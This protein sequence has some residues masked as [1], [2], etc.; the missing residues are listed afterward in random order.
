MGMRP[1]RPIRE[2]HQDSE[3]NHI[4]LSN[5]DTSNHE[6][7]AYSERST[8]VNEDAAM[9]DAFSFDSEKMIMDSS[10]RLNSERLSEFHPPD[11][12]NNIHSHFSH[13]SPRVSSRVISSHEP[14]SSNFPRVFSIDRDGEGAGS[15]RSEAERNILNEFDVNNCDSMRSKDGFHMSSQKRADSEQYNGLFASSRSEMDVHV[16]QRILHS[17]VPYHSEQNNVESMK[18]VESI[19]DFGIDMSAK[20]FNDSYR[21]DMST[22]TITRQQLMDFFEMTES[23]KSLD[24]SARKMLIDCFD[25]TESAKSTDSLSKK[26]LFDHFE[27]SEHARKI[28]T[29]TRNRFFEGFAQFHVGYPHFHISKPSVPQVLPSHGSFSISGLFHRGSN[30]YV[31]PQDHHNSHLNPNQPAEYHNSILSGIWMSKQNHQQQHDEILMHEGGTTSEKFHSTMTLEAQTRHRHSSFSG[32]MPQLWHKKPHKSPSMT[33]HTEHPQEQHVQ[34][35]P[36]SNDIQAALAHVQQMHQSNQFGMYSSLPDIGIGSHNGM[37]T[38][39]SQMTPPTQSSPMYSAGLQQMV[40]GAPRTQGMMAIPTVFNFSQAKTELPEIRGLPRI[41]S[42]LGV[43]GPTHMSTAQQPSN[44]GCLPPL[45]TPDAR[46][47]PIQQTLSPDAS[48]Q[49][50]AQ[51]SL[52]HQSHS[53]PRLLPP[54]TTNSHANTHVYSRSNLS[55]NSLSSLIESGTAT[56]LDPISG[57]RK[58]IEVLKP[59][60]KEKTLSGGGGVYSSSASTAAARGTYRCGK[61]GQKKIDHVC[62]FVDK[63]FKSRGAQVYHPIYNLATNSPFPG[64][65]FLAIRSRASIQDTPAMPNVDSLGGIFPD[66][67]PTGAAGNTCS[68]AGTPPTALT[69]DVLMQRARNEILTMQMSGLRDDD[70]HLK[71]EV[72]ISVHHSMKHPGELTDLSKS[73]HID[74][75]ATDDDEDEDYGEFRNDGMLD[76]YEATFREA[77]AH[78]IQVTTSSSSL[79]FQPTFAGANNGED[80]VGYCEEISSLPQKFVTN[81]RNSS[82][83][84]TNDFGKA[85]PRSSVS[86][87]LLAEEDEMHTDVSSTADSDHTGKFTPSPNVKHHS[88]SGSFSLPSLKGIF[89]G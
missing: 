23:G 89:H 55:D 88:T 38:A 19:D 35:S 50:L 6:G 65:K 34:Q 17:F 3:R 36:H 21:S 58:S 42:A 43:T 53:S 48:A 39:N 74:L 12:R 68:R 2:D 52:L 20:S 51:Y 79:S 46:T 78:Q 28:D 24:E 76:E 81:S 32:V 27:N 82:D 10:S 67:Y 66:A 85:K 45:L 26:E 31:S 72:S 8:K 7:I 1:L 25:N 29:H 13:R 37:Y 11:Q 22:D 83:K 62:K 77:E 9:L 15:L 4:A 75:G 41:H 54:L 14:G 49:H 47:P 71:S 44:N 73:A 86:Q 16:E 56:T 84:S 61:C 5:A 63:T 33:R 18:S 69:S 57:T 30:D 70:R 80:D 60:L 59:V 40:G 87:L 64:E